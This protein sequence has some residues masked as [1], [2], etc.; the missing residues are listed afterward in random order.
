V[1]DLFCGCGGMT[2]GLLEAA[3][4][5]KRRLRIP[6][7]TDD[8][9]TAGDTFL[10]NFPDAVLEP[11]KVE[12]LIDGELGAPLTATE[13]RLRRRGGPVSILVGGPPCQG[14]S[15]LN[16]KT[17][18]NDP[19]NRLYARMARAAVVLRPAV[20]IVENVPQVANDH[21][22]VVEITAE[23]LEAANYRV[24]ATTLDLR[25]VG[26]PQ[27]RRRHVLL[28]VSDALPS[29]LE[30]LD[31]VSGGCHHVRTVGWAIGDLEDIEPTSA[32]DHASTPTDENRARIDKLFR[33]NRHD[34]DNDRLCRGVM[35]GQELAILANA[36]HDVRI[37]D[38][39][40]LTLV[41]QLNSALSSVSAD[42]RTEA[43]R[44][45]DRLDT[46]AAL[47]ETARSQTIVAMPKYDSS[48]V[49]TDILQAH[50]GEPIPGDDKHLLTLLLN[51]GE[52][53]T[54][55][56]VQ[57][58]PWSSLHFSAG[59]PEDEDLA[60]AFSGAIAPLKQ[61]QLMFTYF[62]PDELSPAF[63]ME[64]KAGTEVGFIDM[65]C[66][67]VAGQI[68]GPFVREPY[69]QYLADV[70]A[71]SVGLGLSALQAA[72]QLELSRLGRPELSEFLIHSYRTEGI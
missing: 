24:Y 45:W 59:A 39:S 55:Q 31:G 72:V 23:A 35:I 8:D 56:Q 32:F 18:R 63:R 2:I 57:E 58:D 27:R 19:R 22:Q 7:A 17:R 46:V 49:I 6:L 15:D 1:V 34:L 40:H 64:L 28:A 54:P 70:M 41:I 20:V 11:V 65:L 33:D 52:Y 60:E 42:V 9:T 13:K 61:R 30:I 47:S 69:P 36:P 43:R 62:K 16:N 66:S 10:R 29:P 48:R 71:K 50:R 53:V 68:T 5:A 12:S 3:A 51:E 38:G 25:K 26:V 4:D 44:V 67:T 14:H 21:G 37:L